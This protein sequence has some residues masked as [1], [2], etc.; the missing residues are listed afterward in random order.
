MGSMVDRATERAMMALVERDAAAAREV[1]E[2]DADIN[3]LNFHLQNASISLL[4]LQAPMA[5]DLRVIV[6]VTS[7]LDNLERMGDHAEGIAKIGLM[8]QNEPLVK[9][10]KKFGSVDRYDGFK[11]R[12]CRMTSPCGSVAAGE[13]V[14]VSAATLGR[15]AKL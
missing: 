6:S 5:G 9:P 10:L 14:Q 1:V 8:M 13:A 3:Q 2:R 12:K 15:W 4:S 7:V 11:T